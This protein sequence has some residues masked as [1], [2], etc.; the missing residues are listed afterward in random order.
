MSCGTPFTVHFAATFTTLKFRNE[1]IFIIFYYVHH[2][3]VTSKR[4]KI[5]FQHNV[6]DTIPYKKLV[7]LGFI[8]CTL[9]PATSAALWSWNKILYPLSL[10]ATTSTTSWLRQEKYFPHSYYVHYAVIMIKIYVFI[11]VLQSL[12][13]HHE[14]KISLLLP[15]SL[16]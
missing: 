2:T 15:R 10:I 12:G 7:P 8:K 9:I 6:Y 1:N 11:S 5:S 3:V 13:L 14:K 4:N 16:H